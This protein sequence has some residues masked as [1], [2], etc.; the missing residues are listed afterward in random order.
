MNKTYNTQF[1]EET[2]IAVLSKLKGA[3]KIIKFQDEQKTKM[4]DLIEEQI[5]ADFSNAALHELLLKTLQ[6]L[7]RKKTIAT[8]GLGEDQMSLEASIT[9]DKFRVTLIAQKTRVR[10]CITPEFAASLEKKYG[11]KPHFHLYT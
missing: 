7:G 11:D 4:I 10:V 6:M 2:T 1:S 3:N 9:P 8:Y 5:V